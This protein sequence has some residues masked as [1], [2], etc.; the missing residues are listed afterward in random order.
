MH[1]VFDKLIVF[2]DLDPRSAAVNMAIDELLLRDV[3]APVLRVYRWEKPAVSFGYF[4]EFEPVL[5]AFPDHQLVRRWTG[6]GVV[7][8]GE[9]FTY[10]LVAPGSGRFFKTSP[11]ESYRVI[12][13]RVASALRGAYGIAAEVVSA[14]RKTN[15]RSC[16]ENSVRHDVVLNNRKIA[17]GAQKRAETGLLHQGSIQ[18]V[19]IEPGFVEKLASAFSPAVE[20]RSFEI[21]EAGALAK[22]KYATAAWTRK[23]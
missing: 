11:G 2:D 15:S 13:E 23:F 19:T 12:H 8:H 18:N 7:L 21:E 16:F 4:E 5:S 17:G 10:S 20:L 9:D 22:T 14:E 3:S 6:G 1:P